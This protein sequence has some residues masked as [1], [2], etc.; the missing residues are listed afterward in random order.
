M[1]QFP[2]LKKVA[3]KSDSNS[4]SLVVSPIFLA[5]LVYVSR[6]HEIEIRPSSVRPSLSQLSL[7]LTHRF[8]SNFSCG[9]LWAIP[10]Y[11]F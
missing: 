11:V 4:V 7:N 2:Y 3:L 8:L 1:S 10:L 5:L 9:F 6:D